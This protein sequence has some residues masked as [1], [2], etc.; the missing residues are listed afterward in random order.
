MKIQV[1]G[2]TEGFVG[3]VAIDPTNGYL[4]VLKHIKKGFLGWLGTG[5]YV[6]YQL[7]DLNN[8]TEIQLGQLS[9][10]IGDGMHP[11]N[12]LNFSK[13]GNLLAAA[14]W[15]T[16]CYGLG[17]IYDIASGKGRRFYWGLNL[18]PFGNRGGSERV[19][20]SPKGKW[21]VVA[22]RWVQTVIIDVDKCL[23]EGK[24]EII[25]GLEADRKM[26]KRK[27]FAWSPDGRALVSVIDMSEQGRVRSVDVWS[28]PNGGNHLLT[29]RSGQLL[30]ILLIRC[31]IPI[32]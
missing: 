14:E 19:L 9:P 10:E 18:T 24:L 7:P 31:G 13:S 3:P 1:I 21:L 16:R 20:F 25:M 23:K 28:F 11:W 17:W 12:H 26:S 5:G 32:C 4:A 6:L 27:F 30:M 15:T 22:S 2:T 29:F 8:F